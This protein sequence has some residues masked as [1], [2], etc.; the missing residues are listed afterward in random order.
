MRVSSVNF[1][2][3]FPKNNTQKQV[4][5]GRIYGTETQKAVLKSTLKNAASAYGNTAFKTQKIDK[6]IDS[7]EKSEFIFL[8]MDDNNKPVIMRNNHILK[9]GYS[10]NYQ[11]REMILRRRM[12]LYEDTIHNPSMK[13]LYKLAKYHYI[14]DYEKD[15]PRIINLDPLGLFEDDGKSFL[16]PGDDGYEEAWLMQ[17][18]R[19]ME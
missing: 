5:F 13:T 17:H 2:S 14:L 8:A 18:I 11:G 15:K 10:I 4:N 9:E 19:D 6:A 1:N 3:S 16:S 7:I 12:G